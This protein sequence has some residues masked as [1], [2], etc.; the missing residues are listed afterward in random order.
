MGCILRSDCRVST[1]HQRPPRVQPA[2]KSKEPLYKLELRASNLSNALD[3]FIRSWAGK[4]LPVCQSASQVR[5]F[6]I[7]QLHDWLI[8][9]KQLLGIFPL[10]SNDFSLLYKIL[11][12]LSNLVW[13]IWNTRC[14]F[15]K[16]Q[17]NKDGVAIIK[18][19]VVVSRGCIGSWN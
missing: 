8:F 14:V 19:D 5:G 13:D 3:G 11:A 4:A 17:F 7:L 2:C 15:P 9:E 16:S 10:T 6:S 12:N 1:A 18:K